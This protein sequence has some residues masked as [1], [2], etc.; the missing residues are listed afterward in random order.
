MT[1]SQIPSQNRRSSPGS[2]PR[3]DAQFVKLLRLHFHYQVPNKL[4]T[5]QGAKCP[6]KTCRLTALILSGPQGGVWI[7]IQSE[8]KNSNGLTG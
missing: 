2:Y 1:G 3:T 7:M 8:L 5:I 4:I 6:I